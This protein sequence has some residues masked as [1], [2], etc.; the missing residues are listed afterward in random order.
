MLVMKQLVLLH[1]ISSDVKVSSVIDETGI[2]DPEIDQIFEARQFSW[3]ST[4]GPDASVMVPRTA[5]DSAGT[6][7]STVSH[8]HA[9]WA[10]CNL[11]V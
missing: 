3:K 9:C 10:Q 7:G 5:A 2:K 6:L 1:G 4:P 11:W 8:I